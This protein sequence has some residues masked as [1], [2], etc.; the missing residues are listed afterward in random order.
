MIESARLVQ[1]RTKKPGA[2]GFRSLIFE[3]IDHIRFEAETGVKDCILALGS[4]VTLLL[5]KALSDYAPGV[6]HS[7][8]RILA[9]GC[10]DCKAL[11]SCQI[12]E[13]KVRRK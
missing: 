9:S 1:A 2:R 7:V 3:T 5:T 8:S 11:A 12:V 13:K 6:L 4:Q 10:R